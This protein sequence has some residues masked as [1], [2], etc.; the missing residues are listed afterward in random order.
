MASHYDSLLLA[1]LV[2]SS[3]VF[4]MQLIDT[5]RRDRRGRRSG[6]RL[7]VT[8]GVAALSL[9]LYLRLVAPW[10]SPFSFRFEAIRLTNE[11]HEPVDLSLRCYDK[12]GRLIK[13]IYTKGKLDPEVSGTSW[14]PLEDKDYK[15]LSTRSI[16]DGSILQ[17][18]IVLNP[19]RLL[20]APDAIF[21]S[22]LNLP[23]AKS[24]PSNPVEYTLISKGKGEFEIRLL[25]LRR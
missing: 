5:L 8:G 3:L 12:N 21:D 17:L 19:G 14:R 2:F 20:T 22:A 9:F 4:V 18:K 15:R 7:A 11:E 24:D 10:P 13:R 6:M 25:V 16:T 23:K 1:F